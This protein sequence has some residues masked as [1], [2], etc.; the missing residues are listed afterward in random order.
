M[1]EKCSVQCILDRGCKI[2]IFGSM[3]YF[4]FTTIMSM[5]D[6][7]AEQGKRY[8]HQGA[9]AHSKVYWGDA[10]TSLYPEKV[11]NIRRRG[12][13]GGNFQRRGVPRRPSMSR[14]CHSASSPVGVSGLEGSGDLE[15]LGLSHLRLV[16]IECSAMGYEKQVGSNRLKIWLFWLH[17]KQ[18]D[19]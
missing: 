13:E 4:C 10:L 16:H 8:D 18:L 17:F 5:K 1:N 2:Y 9:V 3:S 12:G 11:S 7:G 19:V 15:S 14:Q 6:A